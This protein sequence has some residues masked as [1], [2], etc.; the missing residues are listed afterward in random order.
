MPPVAW[1]LHLPLHLPLR[2]P[3]RVLAVDALSSSPRAV[4]SSP[5]SADWGGSEKAPYTTPEELSTAAA[6]EAAAAKTDVAF[7]LALGDNFY[8]HGVTSEFDSR[9]ENTFEKAFPGSHL[10]G[11]DFFRVLVGNHDH[12]GNVTAQVEYSNHSKRWRMDD[13]YYSFTETIP[14]EATQTGAAQTIEVVMMDTC[15]ICGFDHV[16]DPAT[17]HHTSS[18]GDKLPTPVFGSPEKVSA[19]AQVA[20]LNKT[21]MSSTADYLIL[22]G[23]YPVYS[24]C[25]HGPTA[26][27]ISEVKPIIDAAGVQIVVAGHDHCQEYI[28]VG[29]TQYHGMG[30]AHTN[31]QSTAHADAVPKDS[32]KWH[33]AG[34]NGG[35][36]MFSVGPNG[37]TATHYSGTGQIVFTAPAIPSRNTATA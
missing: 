35:F 29:A 26:C 20:W 21:L 23:H 25:E 6:M 30:S 18:A 22:A 31:D 34:T 24:I 33:Q 9:F 15:T 27:L 17:G 32:L 11:D 19:D 37:L 1:L 14:A 28:E 2:L 4:D 3:L 10:Q 8:S 12:Y 5:T 36:G 7:A 13:L 16:V